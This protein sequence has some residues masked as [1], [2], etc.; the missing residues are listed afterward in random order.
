MED[1]WSPPP[2]SLQT[3]LIEADFMVCAAFRE[4]EC[5]SAVAVMRMEEQGGGLR[6]HREPTYM[7]NKCCAGGRV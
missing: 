2:S 5:L 3:G 4:E 7:N 1:R 6:A